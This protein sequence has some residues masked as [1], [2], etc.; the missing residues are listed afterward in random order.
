MVTLKVDLTD[1]QSRNLQ[2][3]AAAKGRTV[4][5]LVREGVEVIIQIQGAPSLSEEESEL[6]LA[7]NRGLSGEMA[8]RYRELIRRRQAGT[9]GP[10]EHR[11]LLRLTDEVERQQAERIENL[12]E[13]AR[14]RGL[15]LVALME[16]LGIRPSSNA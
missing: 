12:S 8:E 2:Q 10:E 3:V 16:E 6:L 1:E 14:L 5:D 7:I 15:P 4:A 11:E 13:L 9:L